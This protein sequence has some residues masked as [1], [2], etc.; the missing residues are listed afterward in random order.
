MII[1]PFGIDRMTGKKLNNSFPMPV[2]TN[3]IGIMERTAVKRPLETGIAAIDL[4]FPIG[5]GQR[6]LIIGDKKTGK[7]QICLDTIVNQKDKNVLCIYVSIGKNKKELKNLYAKLIQKGANAYTIIVSAFND[8]LPPLIKLT[9]YIALSIAEYY[10]KQGKD[11]LVCIDDLKKHADACREIALLSEKNTG[12]DAYPA[13]IFYTHS[14]LLE[15][16]CQ[17]QT[18]Q[19]TAH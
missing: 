17:H 9:P 13:D 1:D 18:G 2:E 7:S 4:M 19:K 11:V 5:R 10:L 3:K 16:G 14:R 15:K 8:D 6:Q 12:R